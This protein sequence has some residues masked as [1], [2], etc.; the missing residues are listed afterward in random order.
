MP[1]AFM[2]AR[3]AIAALPH[4]HIATLI[5]PPKGG[6]CFANINRPIVSL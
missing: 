6:F 2:P 4:F 5:K 3:S 1:G